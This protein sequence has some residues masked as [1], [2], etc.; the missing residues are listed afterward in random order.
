[1]DEWKYGLN[2]IG[3]RRSVCNPRPRDLKQV[4]R[5][6]RQQACFNIVRAHWTLAG[7]PLQAT[8]SRTFIPLVG[9]GPLP[10]QP[11]EKA[12]PIHDPSSAHHEG[13]QGFN[14]VNQLQSDDLVYETHTRNHNI[15]CG[16]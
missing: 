2:L 8:T 4:W 7:C 5:R 10:R 11:P 6:G 14:I 1:M 12:P 3:I 13:M 15:R 16:S 9:R